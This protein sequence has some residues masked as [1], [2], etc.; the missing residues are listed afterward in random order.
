MAEQ[1]DARPSMQACLQ[2]L[3]SL[4]G[5]WGLLADAKVKLRGCCFGCR[6]R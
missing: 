2:A 3:E 6:M 4:E 5:A 1:A